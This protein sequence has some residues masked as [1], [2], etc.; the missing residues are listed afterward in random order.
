MA[1]E[2]TDRGAAEGRL[3]LVQAGNEIAL[4]L[5]AARSQFAPEMER[6]IGSASAPLRT[7]LVELQRWRD[8]KDQIAASTAGME[9]ATVMDLGRHAL[10]AGL[11]RRSPGRRKRDRGSRRGELSDRRGGRRFRPCVGPPDHHGRR[12]ARWGS[13]AGATIEGARRGGVQRSGVRGCGAVQARRDRHRPAPC[14]RQS[15]QAPLVLGTM[16]AGEGRR[17]ASRA[18]NQGGVAA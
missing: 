13:A 18:G 12:E 11:F 16:V 6:P 1:T 8:A 17:R 7:I 15:R 3:A 14:H 9:D 5:G 4:I 2:L 10:G